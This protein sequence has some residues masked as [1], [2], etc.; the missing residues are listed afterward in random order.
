[1]NGASRSEPAIATESTPYVLHFE[2]WASVGDRAVKSKHVL[3][4]ERTDFG[5]AITLDTDLNTVH[6]H[7]RRFP[8]YLDMTTEEVYAYQDRLMESLLNKRVD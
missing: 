7:G 1:M 4:I 2:T 8:V 6:M 3:E 5:L